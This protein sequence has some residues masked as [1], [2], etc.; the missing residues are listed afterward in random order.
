MV[1]IK[2]LNT[3]DK[4]VAECIL[5]ILAHRE[6]GPI[7]RSELESLCGGISRVENRVPRLIQAGLFLQRPGEHLEGEYWL[8]IPED[9]IQRIAN[10]PEGFG[11]KR[12]SPWYCPCCGKRVIPKVKRT[13]HNEIVCPRCDTTL[14][15]FDLYQEFY[16]GKELVRKE[17]NIG[18]TGENLAG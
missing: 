16:K 3:S 7:K 18:E 4:V 5:D 6:Q 11:D 13:S 1:K 17:I 8:S 12:H 15:E 10:I 2:K 9:F 14:K